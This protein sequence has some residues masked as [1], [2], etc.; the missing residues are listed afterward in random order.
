MSD[1]LTSELNFG[2][3]GLINGS[4][5]SGQIAFG[6]AAD[7]I[8]GDSAFQWDNTNKILRLGTIAGATAA[9][10]YLIDATTITSG[11]RVANQTTVNANAAGNS[12]ASYGGAFYTVDNSGGGAVTYTSPTYAAGLF[13]ATNNKAGSTISATRAAGSISRWS[14][15]NGTTDFAAGSWGELSL[16]GGTLTSGAALYAAPIIG[17]AGTGTTTYGLLVD[18]PGAGT[19]QWTAAIG[20]GNSYVAGSLRVGASAAPDATLDIT[21]SILSA[22]TTGAT[23]VSGAGVRFM[24]VPAKSAL[25]AGKVS[26][27][28]WDDANIGSYSIS[29]GQNSQSAGDDSVSLGYANIT[30]AQYGVAIG[31]QNNVSVVD[32]YAFGRANVVDTNSYAM[33]IGF[34]NTASGTG[35]NSAIAIGTSNLSS[36]TGAIAIGT[37]N[38]ASGQYAT[39]I[40]GKNL[41]VSGNY[42][43]G[44]NL[45]DTVRTLSQVNSMAI[46]GG[47]VGIGDLTPSHP[48]DV[49]GNVALTGR[50]LQSQG[51]DVASANDLTLGGDGNTFEITGNVQV[52]AITTATWQNGSLVTLG[53][54]GTPTIKHNTA[55]G[56]G[57]A[58][59]Y[60]SG[61][62][63]FGA[64]ANDTL[65]LRLMEIGGT[66]GWYEVAR[67]VI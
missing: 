27:T 30:S 59:I 45:D 62:A 25:R 8:A 39:S 3:A 9:R 29:L 58:K 61:A 11:L 65:T 28:Q 26:G 23:P 66:Q 42:C 10:F 43:F 49:A 34:S 57:T 31:E 19:T 56:A 41:T 53:F 44:I 17:G 20:T 14:N 24:W 38:T 1:S 63:D 18:P 5:S 47:N 51:A 40:G 16:G 67:T 55:G 4:I 32:G 52:N 22:G 50:L 21:G 48:L 64:T 37:S 33:A 54:S 60:L 15:A 6:F 35:S 36:A 2:G 46:M 7:T 12:T 13:V